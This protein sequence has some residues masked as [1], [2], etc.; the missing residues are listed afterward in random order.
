MTTEFPAHVEKLLASSV[1]VSFECP[2]TNNQV[3]GSFDSVDFDGHC[4]TEF[5]PADH[6]I[7]VKCSACVQG[8]HVISYR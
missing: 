2:T 5:S 4:A 3:T 6:V 7:Y 1:V 8:Y